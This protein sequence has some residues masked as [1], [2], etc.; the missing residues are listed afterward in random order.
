MHNCNPVYKTCIIRMFK[1]KLLAISF[2]ILP[3]VFGQKNISQIAPA[4]SKLLVDSGYKSALSLIKKTLPAASNN[5]MNFFFNYSFIEVTDTDGTVPTYSFRSLNNAHFDLASLLDVRYMFLYKYNERIGLMFEIF[6]N[7]KEG[8]F[9]EN[10]MT[11]SKLKIL[12]SLKKGYCKECVINLQQYI[13]K[14]KLKEYHVNIES[15]SEQSG[16]LGER[17]LWTVIVSDKE[18]TNKDS[19]FFSGGQVTFIEPLTSNNANTSKY[20]TPPVISVD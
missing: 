5:E 4:Y 15:F 7:Q 9:F 10:K 3:A 11:L 14:N 12:D 17:F 19:P 2:F 20:L 6:Y 18:S 13:K 16:K 8:A 1:F